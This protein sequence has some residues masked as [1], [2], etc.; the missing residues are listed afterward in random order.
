MTTQLQHNVAPH[1]NDPQDFVNKFL[2]WARG[3][4][5]DLTNEQALSSAVNVFYGGGQESD[6]ARHTVPARPAGGWLYDNGPYTMN[7]ETPFSTG[8]YGSSPLMGWIPT[9]RMEARFDTVSYL[10]YVVPEGWTGGDYAAYLATLSIGACEYGPSSAWS[11]SEAQFPYGEWSVTTDTLEE[12]DFGLHKYE[13]T[14]IMRVRG[15]NISL[16][17]G[18]DAE[19]A[20]AQ[21]GIVLQQH[22]EW[23]LRYG[24]QGSPLQMDGI[25]NLITSGYIALHTV[26]GGT[27]VFSDP[28]EVDATGLTTIEEIVQVLKAI[29]R[30]IFDRARQRGWQIGSN[31]IAIVIP[32]AMWPYILDA[33]AC[34][35]NTNCTG[36]PTGYVIN[37]VRQ[38]RARAASGGFGW[39]TLEVDGREIGVLPDDNLGDNAVVS[40][41]NVVVGDIYVLTR[42][43]SGIPILQQQYLNFNMLDLPPNAEWT[44]EQGGIVRLGW[45]NENHKCWYMFAE[46]QGRL[47]TKMQ[48]MQGRLN[49]VSIDVT[50]ENELESGLMLDTHFALQTT[51]PLVP[52]A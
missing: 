32:S 15:N 22:H 33:I 6:L 41:Q 17:M 25:E 48:P 50:L 24:T 16:P 27:P 37:D 3:K 36:Q 12:V 52:W 13:S 11:G 10:D 14:P 19:W 26:G 31:D 29:V 2:V 20:M 9:T 21:A 43:I 47:V 45:I 28:L 51:D 34:G 46:M 23:I 4:G 1:S 7:D 30:K 42:R 40:G 35:A 18:S 38:E 39:G 5:I 44:T 49:N 8:I